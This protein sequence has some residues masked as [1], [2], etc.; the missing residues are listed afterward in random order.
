MRVLAFFLLNLICVFSTAQMLE[1]QT[2]TVIGRNKTAAHATFTPYPDVV[3]ALTF[4]RS[5]SPW[6]QS[7]SGNWKFLFLPRPGD[8]DPKFWAAEFD[9]SAWD[10]IPV[11]SNWQVL[12]YGTPIYTNIIHPF[13]PTPPI[14]P[15]DKNETGFYRHTFDIP[16]SWDGMQVL[17]HFA[18]VQSA[19]YV[20]VNGTQ[21]GYSEGSMTPAEFDITSYI[22]PG[23]N[24]LAVEVIRWSDGSYLEDQDFWRLSGIFREVFLVAQPPVHIRDFQVETTFG[25]TMDNAAI[26]L[27]AFIANTGK[28]KAKKLQ[29]EINLYDAENNTVFGAVIPALNAIAGMTEDKVSFGWPVANPELWSAETPYL[30]TLTIQ[31]LDKNGQAIEAVSRKIGFRKVEIKNGQ[32]LV[33]EKPIYIKGVNRH[34]SHPRYGRAVTEESMIQDIRLMKQNN[35]NAV[36]TSHYPN[37]TRWYELC[38]QYGLYVF[39]EANMESH[40]LWYMG[41][42]PAKEPTWKDAF[43]DRGVSMVHRD[44]NHPSIIVW[45]LGNETSIGENFFTMADAMKAIDNT[46]PIHYEGRE[47]YNQQTAPEFDIISNMYPS[48]EEALAL[49]EKYPDRPVILCEYAH[50]MGN[51]TGNLDHYWNIFESHPRMQGGFIW[52]WADQGLIK[53]TAD[54]E[55]YFAYGGD[56]GDTPNDKNFCFNGLV[57]PDRLPHP[58]LLE[59]R[60]I[61]QFVKVSWEDRESRKI[62]VKNTYDFQGLGFLEMAWDLVENGKSVQSGTVRDLSVGPQQ[63]Q[64]YT[65]PYNLPQG[66]GDRKEYF[67]NVRF[68]L[69]EDTPWAS[70]GHELA[71]EQLAIPVKTNTSLQSLDYGQFPRLVWEQSHDEFTVSGENFT[72][73]LD[74]N[75]GFITGWKNKDKALIHNGPLPNVWRAPTDND[76]GG[77]DNSFAHKWLTFGL[78]NLKTVIDQV[79]KTTPEDHSIAV[80]V[81]GRL[82]G[83]GGE[84][85]FQ[86][87]QTFLPDGSVQ[88]TTTLIP[89]ANTPPLPKAGTFW[90]L[91][92]EMD[93]VVWYGKGPHES[94]SDRKQSARVGQYGGSVAEQ[95]FPYGRPQ[96]NGNRSEVRWMQITDSNG[97]GLKFSAPEGETIN[98]SAHHYS[99]ENLTGATHPYE[100]KDAGEITLNI[101]HLQMG[102]GGDDSWNPRTHEEFLLKASEYKWTY[103]VK[104]VE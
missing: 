101:D 84:I 4:D 32:L 23:Q 27:N 7:L 74:R 76:E 102:L 77:G 44:K 90:R 104:A 62:K 83:A 81:R 40:M 55:E 19:C 82:T 87:D 18:G 71:F 39:D 16:Q 86:L 54:G 41:K 61:Q 99:L 13:P 42:T 8:V 70:A 29:L 56:F 51:S 97:Q 53:K 20:W 98:F 24:S 68:L 35:I 14:V 64:T 78:N 1:W 91:P 67:L 25:A 63:E 30:Y 79:N 22:H 12:G 96:E 49:A 2:E 11:P 37:Q 100:L 43:I 88:I 57:G 36:R 21:V 46:R 38:D 95:Y 34:E 58:A 103:V 59:V 15:G 60:K 65:I 85:G 6:Y 69:R 31:L 26:S 66:A 48:A 3:K 73:N 47:P 72:W 94:Y 17:L 80:Q 52:D 50:S 45:S 75:T 10:Q 33:N 93:Q 9:D 28:K 89:G 5:K 92:K